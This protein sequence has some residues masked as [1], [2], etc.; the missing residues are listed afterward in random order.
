MKSLINHLNFQETALYLNDSNPNE[1][2]NNAIVRYEKKH[3]FP[4][5]KIDLQFAKLFFQLKPD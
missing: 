3:P 2:R 4:Y 1:P 5:K